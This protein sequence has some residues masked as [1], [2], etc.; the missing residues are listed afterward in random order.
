MK[1]LLITL[2]LSAL[3]FTTFAKNCFESHSDNI[4]LEWTAY[5]TPLKAPVSGKFR[6]LGIT[7]EKLK[8]KSIKDLL[9][10]I[11][12]NIDTA[13]ISTRNTGR[14]AKIVKF[15]FQKMAG[16]INIKG[17]T[18][19]Y[20][21][22]VLKTAITMNN[23]SVIIPLKVTIKDSKI[24]ASGIIDIFDFDMYKSLEGIN[25]AC[26]DLHEGKTWNDVAVKLTISYANTCK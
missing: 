11:S 16:G 1:H 19:K 26:Y 4:N 10:G 13:S 21:K 6:N 24:E 9:Q 7:E 25:K 22:K 18:L 15:F 17:K 23:K 14:D 5:K 3:S 20:E 12:F 8:G 2:L